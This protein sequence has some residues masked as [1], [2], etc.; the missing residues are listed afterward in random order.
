[1]SGKQKKTRVTE[2]LSDKKGHKTA[3][4]LKMDP[5]PD[6]QPWIQSHSLLKESSFNA[7]LQLFKLKV[8]YVKWYRS[9]ACFPYKN[10]NIPK[11]DCLKLPC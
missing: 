4:L 1:M 7:L 5:D 10:E 9:K 11:Y 3:A 6:P 2:W 8:K